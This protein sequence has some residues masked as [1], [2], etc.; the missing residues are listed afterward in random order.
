MLLTI[1]YDALGVMVMVTQQHKSDR[2]GFDPINILILR[3][4]KDGLRPSSVNP[5]KNHT[6]GVSRAYLSQK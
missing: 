1:C 5:D 6:V 3:I 4:Q 2:A